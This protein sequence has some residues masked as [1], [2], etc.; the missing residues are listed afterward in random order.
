MAVTPTP[1]RGDPGLASR[2]SAYPRV[3]DELLLSACHIRRRV[4][5]YPAM[6]PSTEVI[7]D[8]SSE[9]AMQLGVFATSVP[10]SAR[11]APND[12]LNGLEFSKSSERT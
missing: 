4:E 12:P 7:D 6:R 11:T 9:L 10:A 2:P 8:F 5:H 3:L 1:S